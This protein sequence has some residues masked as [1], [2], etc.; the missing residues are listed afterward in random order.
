MGQFAESNEARVRVV[1]APGF[2]VT[3]VPEVVDVPQGDLDMVAR[4]KVNITRQAGYVKPVYLKVEGWSMGA[5]TLGGVSI[6]VPDGAGG[7][8]DYG[9][10]NESVTQVDLEFD[11]F[12]MPLDDVGVPFTVGGYEDEPI[13][14]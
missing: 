14:I 10:A 2:S 9:L 7:F 4:F 5:F 8:K 1:P 11:M 3:V 13:A 12:G 6:M